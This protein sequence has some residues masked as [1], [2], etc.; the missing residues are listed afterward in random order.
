[1]TS[2]VTDDKE[3]DVEFLAVEKD[4]SAVEF[5]LFES[6]YRNDA[7]AVQQV[8]RN[9]ANVNC[10]RCRVDI[11]SQYTTSPLYEAC[12]YGYDEIVRILLDAGADNGRCS[13]HSH[14]TIACWVG[15]LSIV[16]MWLNHDKDLLEIA[17]DVGWTPL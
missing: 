3:S 4:L 11:Q 16:E 5:Q 17:D 12:R 2:N 9:N 15:H 14:M 7:T 10:I 13:P 1:M 6:L 8:I